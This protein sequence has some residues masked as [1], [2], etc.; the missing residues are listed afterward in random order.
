ME[1]PFSQ[2]CENNKQPILEAIADYYNNA[3]MVLEIGSGTGQHALYFAD[4]LKNLY[5]QTSDKKENLEGINLW[6]NGYTRYNLGRPL[7][8]DVMQSRWPIEK[9]DGVFSANTSHMMN[10]QM[11]EHMF[12]GVSG[13]LVPNHS[14]C[15]YGPFNFDGR[16]TSSS[17]EAFDQQLKLKDPE[18]GLK[19][20]ED[21]QRLADDKGLQFIKRHD[22]PANNCLLVWQ[23]PEA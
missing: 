18:I 12:S 8:L 20:F 2:A 10:W 5:W 11:V 21:L 6:L 4:K 23:K 15:L 19:N 9:C 22:L 13:I 1:K 16:Y 14:F 7:I 3:S 17:N